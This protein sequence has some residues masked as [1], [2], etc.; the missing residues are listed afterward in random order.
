MISP[1]SCAL[2]LV[3]LAGLLVAPAAAAE[4][5]KWT[6]ENGVVHYTDRPP[7][8]GLKSAALDVPT[9]P[10]GQPAE[11]P[12]SEPQQATPWYEQ[13]LAEQRERKLQEK[14]ARETAS[15]EKGAEQALMLEECAQARQR[16]KVLETPCRVFFDG[17]GIL[18]SWCR[19]QSTY[20]FS[21]DFRFLEDDERA[22]MIRHY[23]A[24]IDECEAAGY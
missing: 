15:A 9:T 4:V 12:A 14:Q 7:E 2:A 5:Y 19:Y 17:R 10:E 24:K 16:L 21:G 22:G 20:A 11:S 8:R 23:R 18:R 6:D 13:W 3:L 1:N